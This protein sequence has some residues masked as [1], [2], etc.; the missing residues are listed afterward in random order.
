M[1]VMVGNKV[2]NSTEVPIVIEF[3]EKEQEMFNGMKKFVSAPKEST[4]KDR[5]ALLMREIL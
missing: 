4:K 1:K 2:Y 5:E 3:D